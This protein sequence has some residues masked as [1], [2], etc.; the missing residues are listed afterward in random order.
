M[1]PKGGGAPEG[2]LAEKINATFGSF[3]KFK[4]EFKAAALSRFGSG[5]AC[6]FE[7]DDG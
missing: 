2:M 5:W 1:S 3:D 7:A 4:E 6:L